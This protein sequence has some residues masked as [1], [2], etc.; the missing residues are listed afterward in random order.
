MSELLISSLRGGLNNT[1]PPMSLADDQMTTANNVELFSAMLAARRS[2]TTAITLPAFLS[3]KD[4]IPF[5]VRHLP[6]SDET[7]SEFWALGITSVA[8]SLGRK[9]SSWQSEVTISDTANLSGHAP[10]RWQAISFHG[11][12]FILYDSNVDRLHVWD[13]TSLRRVGL[14]EPA[15]PTVA[16]SVPAGSFTGTRFYRVRYTVQSAGTTI[17]RSEPSDPYEFAPSGS[18]DGAVITK[19]ASISEGET[20]WEVEASVD[21][22]NFYVIATTAVG[23]TTVTDTQVYAAGYATDFELSEDIGDYTLIHSAKYAAVDQDRLVLGGSWEDGT[24]SSRI[25]WTPVFGGPGVGN[26]ER[27]ELDTDPF[28]DLDGFEGG[29]LTGLSNPVNGYMYAFKLNHTYRLVR[30]GLRTRAYEARVLSKDR[31]AIDGSVVTGLD[32]TGAPCVYFLDPE[33]GP[34]RI[35]KRGIESCGADILTTWRTVNVEAT[36]VVCSGIYHSDMRQVIWNVATDGSNVPNMGLILH[37][38]EVRSVDDGARRGWTLWTGDRAKALTMCAYS[39]NIDSN[40]TRSR[41]LEPFIGL[42]GL[43]LIHR[44]ETGT[45]D[46]GV[47]FT[48]SM[49]SKPY[50]AGNFMNDFGVDGATLIAKPAS[51]QVNVSLTKD[52]GIEAAKT[53]SNV[54]TAAVGSETQVIKPIPDLRLSELGTVQVTIADGTTPGTWQAN[55]LVLKLIAGRKGY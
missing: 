5:M 31:C 30:T 9:T 25:A 42:E 14:A 47:T 16:N 46:N 13:G 12:L 39:D 6:T 44:C 36:K 19:P 41:T 23:T 1:D 22:T 52:F 15:A 51:S 4:S 17:I 37:T 20:H 35:G 53:V 18:K 34:C 49:T 2:G 26:D 27:L 3:N 50:T 11:K 54:S 28:I 40:T 33:T 32:E 10:Y 8:A 24:K 55:G 38:N 29:G 45:T 48:A 43:G 21:G 7:A